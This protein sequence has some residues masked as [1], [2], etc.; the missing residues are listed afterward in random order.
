MD[1]SKEEIKRTAELARLEFTDEELDA[2]QENFQKIVDYVGKIDQLE[3]ENV[4]P[5]THIHDFTRN[6]R[7]DEGKDGLSTA[8]ALKNAPKKSDT[9]FKVPKVLEGED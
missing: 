3:L 2:F 4:A 1:I 9:Y 8:D 6:T 7:A 5:M